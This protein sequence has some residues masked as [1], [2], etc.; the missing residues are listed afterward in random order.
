MRYLLES[1]QGPGSD[2]VHIVTWILGLLLSELVRIV[3]FSFMW[4]VNIRTSIRALSAVNG[5][6]Y[7]K[8]T[9]VRC[10]SSTTCGGVSFHLYCCNFFNLCFL[11]TFLF[12]PSSKK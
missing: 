3:F 8:L 10:L 6:L 5:L 9:K 12:S 2:E 7:K 1:I 11:N 4:A